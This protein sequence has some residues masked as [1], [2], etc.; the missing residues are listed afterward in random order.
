[1]NFE[2]LPALPPNGGVGESLRLTPD[3][4]W[5]STQNQG[6]LHRARRISEG[7]THTNG[8]GRI[9]AEAKEVDLIEVIPRRQRGVRSD[10]RA[11]LGADRCHERGGR[12]ERSH[13]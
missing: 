4:R 5:G 1:M 12:Y 10:R 8:L 3:G 6:A 13:R 2:S 7:D 11:E 9:D